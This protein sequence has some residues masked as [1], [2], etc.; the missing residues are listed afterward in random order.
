V[1][2]TLYS[3][4][5]ELEEDAKARESAGWY[6]RFL[7]DRSLIHAIEDAGQDGAAWMHAAE[8]WK[9]AYPYRIEDAPAEAPSLVMFDS[10]K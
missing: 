6:G 9:Q 4:I 7:L 8:L 5:R 2:F 3:R 1:R 10:A